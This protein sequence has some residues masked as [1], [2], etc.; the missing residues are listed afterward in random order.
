[1]GVCSNFT[2]EGDGSKRAEATPG[3]GHPGPGF[4]RAAP[5]FLKE[6]GRSPYPHGRHPRSPGA[7]RVQHL[8]RAPRRETPKSVPTTE[9]KGGP[10]GGGGWD[11]GGAGLGKN[12][13][14]LGELKVP[15]TVGTLEL[16]SLPPGGSIHWSRSPE[17]AGLR[18]KQSRRQETL[19]LWWSKL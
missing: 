12:Q 8:G 14:R 10:G 6:P 16:C 18:F 15:Q 13:L 9:T 17:A 11:D 5:P 3:R 1:M 4:P 7:T 2:C 19:T